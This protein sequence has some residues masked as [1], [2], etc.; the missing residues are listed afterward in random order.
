MPIMPLK[1]II[2]TLIFLTLYP[3]NGQRK[4]TDTVYVYEKVIVYDTIYLEKALKIQPLGIHFKSSIIPN[5]VPVKQQYEYISF[6][7]TAK[8]IAIRPRKFEY[9]VE[10]GI[11]FKNSNWA[12]KSSENR[13]QLG[14]NAGIW[15]SGSIYKRFSLMLSANVYHWNS[16]FDLD[17]NR[18]DTWLNGYYFTE[19][20][21]PILFQKFNNKHFEYAVQ[22]KLFYEWKKIRPFIGFLANQNVY[23]M[24]FMVPENNILNKLEDFKSKQINPGYSFGVQYRMTRKFLLSLEYQ[25]YK[26]RN[27]SLKNRAFNFDIFK[28][29]NTFAERKINLGVSYTISGW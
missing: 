7:D 4:K 17:A 28:T 3:L 12:K 20:Q 8:G 25:E 21:Q 23:T 26:M 29:N 11:G 15:I 24:Q 9:G 19:D 16:T 2:F 14:F 6:M 13:Q 27:I 5:S 10:A 18:E 22:L 1:K